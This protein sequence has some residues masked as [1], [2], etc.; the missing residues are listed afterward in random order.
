[1]TTLTT[2]PPTASVQKLLLRLD[3]PAVKQLA[4]ASGTS[5]H[6]IWKIRQGIVTNPGIETVREFMPALL[7]MKASKT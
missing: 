4:E 2:P 1:M 3:R 7:K 5:F 6:T